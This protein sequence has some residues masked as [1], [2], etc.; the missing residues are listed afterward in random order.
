[1]GTSISQPSPSGSEPGGP[2]WKD[3]QDAIKSGEPAARVTDKILGAFSAE[4]GDS[5]LE[6]LVDR[7]VQI[8]S[9]L[10]R[11]TNTRPGESTEKLIA[12]F[13]REAKKELAVASANSFF[14][15]LAITAAAKALANEPAQIGQR[16]SSEYLASVFDY[17]VSRDLPKTIGSLGLTNLSAVDTL[18]SEIRKSITKTVRQRGIDNPADAL[19]A[20]LPQRRRN[21]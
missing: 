18:L 1:M 11:Q 5:A 21:D 2:E 14:A 17:V 8:V 20:I 3:A 15:E 12:R 10:A 19:R 16:L 13:S 9:D 6:K 7:G 4:Y